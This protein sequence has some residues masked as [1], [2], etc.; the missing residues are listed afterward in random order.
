MSKV[1]ATNV[2]ETIQNGVDGFQAL[3]GSPK[4]Y[5]QAVLMSGDALAEA[6]AIGFTVEEIA[7]QANRSK[8]K[9]DRLF[10]FHAIY[11]QH[12]TDPAL[13]DRKSVV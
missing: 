4:D 10:H 7:E 3:L 13:I 12:K 8:S 6:R 2:V 1:M 9:V 5:A 11:A